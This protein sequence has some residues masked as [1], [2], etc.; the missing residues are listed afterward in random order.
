MT[1]GHNSDI[2]GSFCTEKG[3]KGGL[4]SDKKGATCLDLL[5]HP[6]RTT[7]QKPRV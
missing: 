6:D 4:G 2:L 7:L 1:G 3:F 5:A